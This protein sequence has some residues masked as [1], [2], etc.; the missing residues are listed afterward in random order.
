M[1]GI[2]QILGNQGNKSG[3]W[4]SRNQDFSKLRELLRRQKSWGV[5][6]FASIAR[7]KIGFYPL[8]LESRIAKCCERLRDGR[9]VAALTDTAW[10]V[11]WQLQPT[12]DVQ[13]QPTDL[14]EFSTRNCPNCEGFRRWFRKSIFYS[15]IYS[16]IF[17]GLIIW[18]S[19]VSDGLDRGFSSHHSRSKTRLR[20]EHVGKSIA[21]WSGPEY[22]DVDK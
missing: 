9:S 4:V 13:F 7:Q 1:W 20:W 3:F 21:T 10:H 22:Q 2:Q 12:T 19:S 8:T 5:E 16:K 17:H 18:K 6:H 14:E 11:A 15:M